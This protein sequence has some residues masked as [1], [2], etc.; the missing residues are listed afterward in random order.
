[1]LLFYSSSQS[2]Q[3][4]VLIEGPDVPEDSS[5]YLHSTYP[6]AQGLGGQGHTADNLRLEVWHGT[7]LSNLLQHT[8]RH[9]V[10]VEVDQLFDKALFTYVD[11][12]NVRIDCNKS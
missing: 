11:N 2:L 4:F 5:V 6:H 7:V 12:N 8:V 3:V 9:V 10:F 1:M